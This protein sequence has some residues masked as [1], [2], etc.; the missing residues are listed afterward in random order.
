MKK[1][2]IFVFIIV[3]FISLLMISI[4]SI[5]AVPVLKVKAEVYFADGKPSVKIIEMN[6]SEEN[7]LRAPRGD[8]AAEFPSVTAKAFIAGE[9]AWGK[10]SYWAAKEYRGNGT[11]D[12][13]VGFPRGVMPKHGDM[14]KVMV[15]VYDERG[16]TL[17]A[18][19][20][21]IMWE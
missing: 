10:P 6:Q 12:F 2:I 1:G 20:K 11:Y 9:R 5:E 3:G 18:D 15:W 21:I 14:V 7:P 13:E 16:K 8:S 19:T 4:M 17:A